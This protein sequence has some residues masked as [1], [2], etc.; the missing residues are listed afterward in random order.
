MMRLFILMSREDSSV[1]ISH[2]M[3]AILILLALLSPGCKT[4]T[5]AQRFQME[6]EEKQAGVAAQV[7]ERNFNTVNQIDEEERKLKLRV[8]LVNQRIERQN[9]YKESIRLVQ[10]GMSVEALKILN[11]LVEENQESVA[12]YEKARSEGIEDEVLADKNEDLIIPPMEP[13]EKANMLVLIGAAN[14]DAGSM[15][16]SMTAYREATVV[17]PSNRSAR[18]NL[19]KLLF[20]AGDFEGALN[21]FQKEMAAGFRSGELLF[22]SAQALLEV[23]R[24]KGDMTLLEAA[25]SAIA[26]ARVQDPMSEDLLRWGASLSIE[27]KRYEE[28]ER[29]L[30]SILSRTPGDKYYLGLLAECYR[31]LQMWE[32]AA[33]TLE[34][35]IRVSG[36]DKNA[37]LRL[38]DIYLRNLEQPDRAAYWFV[39]SYGGSIHS[40]P[41]NEKVYYGVLLEEAGKLVE[42]LEVFDSVGG[43]EDNRADALSRKASLLISM[44]RGPEAASA[45]EAVSRLRK[46][47]G[48]TYLL[49]GDLHMDEGNLKDAMEA[50]GEA[51]ALPESK[52]EGFAGLA[53]VAYEQGRLNLAISNY[54]KAIAEKPDDPRFRSALEQIREEKKLL[55]TNQG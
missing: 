46:N 9:L 43:S 15:E 13:T 26:E 7:Q 50:Y 14:Y 55:E 17:D 24:E 41:E 1:K 33:D 27:L 8:L 52:A 42:A 18:I 30:L 47:D 21:S 51:S 19:G 39:N 28:A 23:G 40:I 34:L 20:M 44:Q 10:S 49:L 3:T 31:N 32:K 36:A 29:Q 11:R 48:K 54:E 12:I 53:E 2:G 6:Q 25:R 45:L 22:L 37:C 4:M 16:D 38:H 35:M 5:E